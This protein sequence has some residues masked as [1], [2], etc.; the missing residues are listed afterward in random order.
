MHF[1]N[2]QSDGYK[3]LE[4]GAPVTYRVGEGRRGAEAF[5]VRPVELSA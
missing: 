2:I 1:T 4:L 3:T 5:D